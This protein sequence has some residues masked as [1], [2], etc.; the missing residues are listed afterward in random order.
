MQLNPYLNFDG[1]CREAFEFYAE[2]LGGR[3]TMMQTHGDSPMKEQT[4]PDW[5]DAII[6]ARLE[7]GSQTLMGSDYPPG[8]HG[9]PQGFSLSIQVDKPEDA[10]RIFAALADGGKIQM[11]I[12]KTFWA[13]RFGMVADRYGIPWMVNCD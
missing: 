3:V 11:P 2:L 9:K 10:D 1:K 5:H 13:Q 6:H 12:D 4:S 8:A 7:L